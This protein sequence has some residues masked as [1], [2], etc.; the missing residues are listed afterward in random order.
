M[1][2]EWA[3]VSLALLFGCSGTPPQSELTPKRKTEE[4]KERK[5]SL[6]ER[7]P[8]SKEENPRYTYERTKHESIKGNGDTPTNTDPTHTSGGDDV[9][10]TQR[11]RSARDP[12]SD[13]EKLRL[14]LLLLSAG[15]AYLPEAE[16]VLATVRRRSDLLPYLEAWLYR[17]LGETQKSNALHTEL[18]DNW[19]QAEGF[20]IE[21]G[22]LVTAVKGF[23]RYEPHSDGKVSPG[24]R[25]MIYLQPRNFT[26]KK[27][28][29]R[30]TLH[31]GYDWK[32]YDDRNQEIAIPAWEQCNPNDRF[33]F[34]RY[35]AP[36][37]E[38]H[39]YFHL[40]LPTNLAV[41]NYRIR[42]TATDKWTGRDDR[43][44][45]PFYVVPKS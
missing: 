33:D 20:R 19:R 4:A 35:N 29:D 10:R 30:H 24:G 11:E 21:R 8:D 6:P 13:L 18:G 36:V 39:Q 16:R 2:G 17:K 14:A 28:G 22:E 44:Y 41:G 25:V 32:L 5:D 31:L 42:V 38:F 9:L 45:V 26:L 1:R 12:S 27:D 40:P 43:I 3:I 37:T 23:G 7:I 34:L 15:D